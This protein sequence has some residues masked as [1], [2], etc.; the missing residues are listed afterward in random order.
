MGEFSGGEPTKTES[1]IAGIESTSKS[2][3]ESKQIGIED[4]LRSRAPTRGE[5]EY[6][7]ADLLGR[8]FL[9]LCFWVDLVAAWT[10]RGRPLQVRA[11]AGHATADS[12]VEDK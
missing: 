3:L 12:L 6:P 5:S 2:I 11:P 1:A 9:R 7:V 4:D 8:C 10:R